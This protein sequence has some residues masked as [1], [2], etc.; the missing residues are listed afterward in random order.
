MD[1]IWTGSLAKQEM[2]ESFVLR[3]FAPSTYI[4]HL[5]IFHLD[6]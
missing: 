5:A 1:Q 3:V 4:D 2:N 6:T